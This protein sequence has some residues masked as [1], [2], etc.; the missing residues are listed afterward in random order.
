MP[1]VQQENTILDQLLLT[2]FAPL[3]LAKDQRLQNFALT[4]AFA[5]VSP[6]VDQVAQQSAEFGNGRISLLKTLC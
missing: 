6:V 5:V 4:G 1:G 3:E 2:Q